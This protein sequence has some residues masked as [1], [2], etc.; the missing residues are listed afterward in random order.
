M[1]TPSFTTQRPPR[2]T[3]ARLDGYAQALSHRR[4]YLANLTVIYRDQPSIWPS[5]VEA[6]LALL[7]EIRAVVNAVQGYLSRIEPTETERIRPWPTIAKLGTVDYLLTEIVC[8]IA[9]FG[10]VCQATTPERPRLH[11]EI[12][13]AFPTCLASYDD[14]LAQLCALADKARHSWQRGA[15]QEQQEQREEVHV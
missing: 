2:S 12:R 1:R 9:M 6:S 5:Q 10:P 3:A 11:I 14:L 13:A 15:A 4:R 7:T 8:N